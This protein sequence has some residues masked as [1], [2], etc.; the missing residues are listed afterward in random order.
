MRQQIKLNTTRI[1]NE[2]YDLLLKA[3]VARENKAKLVDSANKYIEVLTPI[4][5]KRNIKIASS[6]IFFNNIGD[7]KHERAIVRLDFTEKYGEYQG[8][9]VKRL[10]KEISEAGI[11]TPAGSPTRRVVITLYEGVFFGQKR[12]E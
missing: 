5:N 9:K 10:E 11:P 3:N 6:Q 1:D 7:N 12:S 4:L 8:I 2:A